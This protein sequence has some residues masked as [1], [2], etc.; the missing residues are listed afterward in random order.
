MS[1]DDLKVL[2]DCMRNVYVLMGI[3]FAVSRMGGQFNQEQIKK[4]SDELMDEYRRIEKRR[5]DVAC[6]DD[7]VS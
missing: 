3:E 4:L 6:T 5:E 2:L 7:T 1:N